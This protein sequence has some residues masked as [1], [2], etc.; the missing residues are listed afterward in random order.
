[1]YY[2]AK[3]LLS[4]VLCFV[5]AP[6]ISLAEIKKGNSAAVTWEALRIIGGLRVGT[7]FVKTSSRQ[8][9]PTYILKDTPAA[10]AFMNL[11]LR[12]YNTFGFADLERA[13]VTQG[14]RLDTQLIQISG[15]Y[16]KSK[17]E[18]NCYDF[19]TALMGEP[20]TDQNSANLFR[21]NTPTITPT[22]SI[23]GGTVLIAIN[24]SA[25][26]GHAVIFLKKSSSHMWVIDQNGS[27][28]VENGRGHKMG[29]VEIRKIPFAKSSDNEP[30]LNN[31][32]NYR[33]IIK[34]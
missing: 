16:S 12:E 8:S 18:G 26:Q 34:K 13:P 5:L 28:K 4:L 1:M 30:Y 17:N 31:A 14:E 9:N 20:L 2:F 22:S 11:N 23:R 21:T 27:Y 19:V 10:Q 32:Y 6:S 24:S 33:T 3:L 29:L 7:D 15:Y 25:R